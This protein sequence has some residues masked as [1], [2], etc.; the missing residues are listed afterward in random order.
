MAV[1]IPEL[2]DQPPPFGRH[3]KPKFALHGRRRKAAKKALAEIEV[4]SRQD[5]AEALRAEKYD[6]TPLLVCGVAG[7]DDAKAFIR[8]INRLRAMLLLKL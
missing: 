6:Q 8:C 1:V 3:R 4:L 2:E 5:V 7:S